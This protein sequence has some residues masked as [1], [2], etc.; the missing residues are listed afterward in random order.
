[1]WYRLYG[2]LFEEKT[3]LSLPMHS[4]QQALNTEIR[5]SVCER[6]MVTAVNQVGVDVAGLLHSDFRQVRPTPAPLSTQ[7]GPVHTGYRN[8][9]SE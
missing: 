2:S 4:L 9:D 7:S 8:S 5:L 1:M 3:I 6:F